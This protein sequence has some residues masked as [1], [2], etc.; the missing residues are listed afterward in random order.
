[1]QRLTFRNTVHVQKKRNYGRKNVISS[2]IKSD[3]SNMK[4]KSKPNEQ[5]SSVILAVL[6]YQITEAHSKLNQ[7][8]IKASV[9]VFKTKT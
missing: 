3:Q 7:S 6:H 4:I 5:L 8:S 1:M 2:V 9:L